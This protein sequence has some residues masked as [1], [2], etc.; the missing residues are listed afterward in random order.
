MTSAS[1]FRRSDEQHILG[2][3][4]MALLT[5]VCVRLEFNLA[6]AAFVYLILITVLSRW[7]NFA[8][9]VLLSIAAVGCLTYFFAPPLFSL[10]ME[11]PDYVAGGKAFSLPV[12]LVNNR[13]A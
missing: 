10:R 6:E 4:G 7:G 8:G 11:N 12:F 1:T 2:G 13:V 3:I 5:F 9:S